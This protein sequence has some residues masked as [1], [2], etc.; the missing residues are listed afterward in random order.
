MADL[1]DLMVILMLINLVINYN[2]F[3]FEK[4]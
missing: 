3:N 2:C 1:I 4:Y